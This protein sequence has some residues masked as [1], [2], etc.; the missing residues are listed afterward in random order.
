ME[1]R[2]FGRTNIVIYWWKNLKTIFHYKSVWDF[3]E[4]EG[5]RK[6]IYFICWNCSQVEVPASSTHEE[7]SYRS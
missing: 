7:Q 2:I 4:E 3:G 6:S 5:L 1:Y